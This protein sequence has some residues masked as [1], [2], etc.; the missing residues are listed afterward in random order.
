MLVTIA[1]GI[2][3]GGRYFPKKL[4][5]E[6]V[7]VVEVGQTPGLFLTVPESASFQALPGSK[8]LRFQS[9][10]SLPGVARRIPE[11]AAA[12]PLHAGARLDA[13]CPSAYL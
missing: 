9:A 8:L 6:S 10:F 7:Q 1:L 4:L 12:C 2:P 5:L 3:A 11:A 13:S